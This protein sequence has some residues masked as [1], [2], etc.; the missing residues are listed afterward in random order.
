[1][2]KTQMIALL[3]ASV[4]VFCGLPYP[5]AGATAIKYDRLSE[6]FYRE[7]HWD[8]PRVYLND[9]EYSEA[10]GVMQTPKDAG[11]PTTATET[12]PNYITRH[13]TVFNDCDAQKI[14]YT[15]ENGASKTNRGTFTTT[16]C[17]NELETYLRANYSGDALEK[18]LNDMAKL[19]T[20]SEP[21]YIIC[22]GGC[23]VGKIEGQAY[24]NTPDQGDGD[25]R[26]IFR[27]YY[28]T[29]STVYNKPY[30]NKPASS[31][32]EVGLNIRDYD[33]LEFDL[34]VSSKMKLTK[35]RSVQPKSAAKVTLYYETNNG[36]T[37]EFLDQDAWCIEGYSYM[38][39]A[40]QLK[41]NAD[42]SYANADKWVTIR[43]AL[44]NG[45]KTAQT[46][47][48]VKQVTI[49]LIGG[50]EKGVSDAIAI[51]DVRF[52]K[53]DDHVGKIYTDGIAGYA[54]QDYPAGEYF[55]VNDFEYTN[56]QLGDTA[57][58]GV[59]MRYTKNTVDSA[60]PSYSKVLRTE[61]V[62]T[63]DALTYIKHTA[64]EFN[65]SDTSDNKFFAAP[66]GV[67]TQ[68]NYATAIKVSGGGSY[69]G[70]ASGWHLP[71]YY[72]RN[73][74]E[75]MDLSQFTHFA[76]DVY[77]R[78]TGKTYGIK[79][80]ANSTAKGVTFDLALFENLEETN[81]NNKFNIKNGAD[82]RFFLPYGKNP[83]EASVS[84]YPGGSNKNYGQ[85][86][87]LGKL[88]HSPTNGSEYTAWGAMRLVFTREQLLS[89][90]KGTFD[91]TN[92][93]GMQFAW[94]N[95]RPVSDGQFAEEQQYYSFPFSGDGGSIAADGAL[96]TQAY[97]IIL[98]N[99]IA[100]TPYTDITIKN[101]VAEDVLVDG[102]TDQH[103]LYTLNG[104]YVSTDA[105][106]LTVDHLGAQQAKTNFDGVTDPITAEQ[107]PLTVALA[108]NQSVTIRS[109]PFQ[110]YYISQQSWSWRY[111]VQNISCSTDDVLHSYTADSNVNTATILPR[112]S[113]DG[114]EKRS[115]S[116]L[117][118]M[119]QRNFTV[120]FTQKVMNGKWLSDTAYCIN[121]FQ[122]GA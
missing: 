6:E 112:I 3:L 121:R 22:G 86:I 70:G 35:E 104:G 61:E 84:D 56:N 80:P 67:V 28:N 14:F 60:T 10:V 31:S 18:R 78:V 63:D 94:L 4:L 77:I 71:T 24:F 17:S 55:M 42:G 34:W 7:G 66:Y 57:Q 98:D 93:K 38:S 83:W 116:I 76:I 106:Y 21:P 39:Y 85:I 90:T 89:A 62:N 11:N 5:R 95:R 44:P 13:I 64:T 50:M 36:N 2:K 51:D 20:A 91:L 108:A 25:L 69:F 97:D 109:V 40:G 48:T 100:Y 101:E 58:T 115:V 96:D 49:R 82:L 99:F 54:A 107:K 9:R 87:P 59:E 122:R 23:A 105:A 47:P 8:V 110:S 32:E 65:W 92:V 33:Y 27:N 72:V 117:D 119:K 26:M 41:W 120:T 52:V 16:E 37:S 19:S 29:D 45:I 68:G 102:D 46:E 113:F 103:F 88:Y 1:M 73:Y 79:K 118:V 75:A 81:K 15:K 30:Q 114:S 12:D 74:K 43:I 53:N 111:G